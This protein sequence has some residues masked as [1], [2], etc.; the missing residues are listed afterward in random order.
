M[1]IFYLCGRK[2]PSLSSVHMPWLPSTIDLQFRHNHY[3]T[4]FLEQRNQKYHNMSF[5]YHYKLQ[6]NRNRK[7]YQLHSTWQYFKVLYRDERYRFFVDKRLQKLFVLVL[8]QP[9]AKWVFF[10]SWSRKR[11]CLATCTPVLSKLTLRHQKNHRF[12]GYF[13][14]CSRIVFWSLGE[15]DQP[16]DLILSLLCLFS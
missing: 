4:V 10:V 6:P 11:E 5:F 8:L 3:L 9:I 1:F 2:E 7:V 14:G 15:V 12:W 13:R 16:L